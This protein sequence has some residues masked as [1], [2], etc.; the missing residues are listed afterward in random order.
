MRSPTGRSPEGP[1][2]HNIPIRTELGREI[3]KVFAPEPVC[4]EVD[5]AAH[6]LRLVAELKVP[7]GDD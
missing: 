3:R 4:V 5:Y 2:L 6:E 1:A 7:R